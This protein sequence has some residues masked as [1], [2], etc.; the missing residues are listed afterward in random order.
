MDFSISEELQSAQQL[1][2][3][4]LG[5]FTADDK[6]QA[7]EQQHERYDPAL[8]QALADA[9]LLGLDIDEAQGG[10]GLGYFSLTMLCEEVGRTVA[11]VPVVPVLVGAAGILRRF[12]RDSQRDQWLPG[13]AGG[14]L[15][16]TSALE[17]YQNDDPAAPGTTA[18]AVDGGYALSG[19]KICV[20]AAASAARIL[21]S[22]DADGELVVAL[23]DPKAAGVALNPQ[24]VTSG[25]TRHELVMDRV[26][27]PAED[28]VATGGEAHSAMSVGPAGNPHRTVGDGGRPVRQ[29]DAHDRP[30][31]LGARAIRPAH[32]HLP[33]GEPSRRGLLH[34]RGVPAPGDAA[35]G[36][37]D[38]SG[39]PRGGRGG[40]GEAVVR[41]RRP[42]RQPGI[43][44]LPRRHRG[45]PGLPAVSLLPDGPADR[46]IRGQQCPHHR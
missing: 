26:Q 31:H 32:R 44:A 4:I 10:M 16:V 25:E 23:V 7:V 41:R 5:D 39:A 6:L 43:P 28:V 3:Q 30:V 33:G 24:V 40:D 29:D 1:A 21:V 37:A 45:G 12:G 17:E 34:R 35:G 46:A 22:A 38:R 11:P 8:W 36:F 42:P 15:L 18:E 27:V 9:G 2:A 13:I 19:T 20:E 14:S